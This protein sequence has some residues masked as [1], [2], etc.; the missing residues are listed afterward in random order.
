MH[1]DQTPHRRVVVVVPYDPVWP[2]EF[3]RASSEVAA[4]L[5]P[6][7][8]AVHHIGS[9][10]IPGIHAKPVIDMLAVVD[11]PAAVDQ[12]N[13]EMARLGY[14]AMGE[15]GIDG[16]RYFRRD[17]PTGR[18][19]H[20][21]HAFAHGSPHVTRLLAFRDFMRAHPACAEQYSDLKRK[22]AEAH[23]RD[24]EAYMDGKDGF[25]K[26]TERRALEWR[27]A[28][29]VRHR[30]YAYITHG[31][32]LLVFRHVN[33]PEAGLQVPAGTI[34]AGEDPAAAALREAREET[35]LD[36]LT[37]VSLLVRDERDMSDCGANE[38]QH[39]WFFHLRCDGSPPQTWRHAETSDG[40]EPIEFEFFW[41][42]LPHGVPKL[43]A[44]YDAYVPQLWRAVSTGG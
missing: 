7:L 23:P 41:A 42:D 24:I 36:R 19:T 15:F 11:D 4:A 8:L 35:G 13:A 31:S 27:A 38:L 3:A 40:R 32:R 34:E 17:D 9:T 28:R 12:R 39:R 33:A 1:R 2:Q 21:I 44:D 37:L 22:L 25:I 10:S 20:Q 6:N 5:G 29:R 14:E 16:R 30:A 18:R 43:V 26:E